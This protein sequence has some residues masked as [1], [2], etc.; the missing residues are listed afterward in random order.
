MSYECHVNLSGG[1]GGTFTY[2]IGTDEV[3]C[4][5]C[6]IELMDVS[7]M[8]RSHNRSRFVTFVH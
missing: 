8:D 5:S 6:T 7:P 2:G 1:T 4:R 3:G